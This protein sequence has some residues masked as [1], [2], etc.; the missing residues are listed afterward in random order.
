MTIN[1]AVDGVVDFL[2]GLTALG[3]NYY[4]SVLIFAVCLAAALV[5]LF[6]SVAFCKPKGS[7]IGLFVFY[8]I[9]FFISAL[10]CLSESVYSGKVFKNVVSAYFFC[11]AEFGVCLAFVF[12]LHVQRRTL[13]KRFKRAVK[14]KN[15]AIAPKTAVSGG[16]C[17]FKPKELSGMEELKETN[18]STDE[19]LNEDQIPT[20]NTASDLPKDFTCDSSNSVMVG[21]FERRDIPDINVNYLSGLVSELLK[22]SLSDEDRQEMEDLK[23]RLKRLPRTAEEVGILN[24]KLGLLFKRV[25][26]YGIE[27]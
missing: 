22:K 6:L 16:V 21:G 4:I 9:C 20:I 8:E 14:D 10:L 25:A 24:S 23:F 2:K 5:M 15:G 7:L 3:L 27:P 11:L 12:A 18:N 19:P 13:N 17:D 26:D 1:K